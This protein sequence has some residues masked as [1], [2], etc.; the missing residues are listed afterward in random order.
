MNNLNLLDLW[1]LK[2]RGVILDGYANWIP[3]PTN[4]WAFANRG[5]PITKQSF[6][7][8]TSPWGIEEYCKAMLPDDYRSARHIAKGLSAYITNHP[9]VLA[10]EA[11][12]FVKTFPGIVSHKMKRS[13]KAIEDAVVNQYA[14]GSYKTSKV[15]ESVQHGTTV[16]LDLNSFE[17]LIRA[18][19]D[20]KLKHLKYLGVE[21]LYK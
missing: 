17:R 13:N 15:S 12:L 16:P 6:A 2:K 10:E 7:T 1:A 8:V 19:Y 3:Q 4:T 9:E 18:G 11:P 14:E 21:L 5:T 20:S